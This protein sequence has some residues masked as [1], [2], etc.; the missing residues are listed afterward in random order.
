[1]SEE[2]SGFNF[3][4]GCAIGCAGLIVLAILAAGGLW[5]FVSQ[6]M[7][8]GRVA[9]ADQIQTDFNTQLEEANIPEERIDLMTELVRLATD[10]NTSFAMVLMC[11]T[12]YGTALGNDSDMDEAERYNVVEVVI[13]FV[14]EDP[15]AGFIKMGTFISENPE[16][17]DLFEN[18]EDRGNSGDF[19][20]GDDN[21]D[22]VSEP[23]NDDSEADGTQ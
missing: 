3:M 14:S 1:M 11:A 22:E 2:K 4:K 16:Y 15:G 19:E 6:S 18:L 13:D 12:A 7:E 8:A 21:D 10:D 23:P 5:Y 17:G 20:F 9:I